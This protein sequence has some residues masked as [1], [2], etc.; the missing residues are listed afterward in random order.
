M[1]PT[2]LLI[3]ASSSPRRQELIRFLQLP[4]IVRASYAK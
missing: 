1:P 4:F 2:S 3:L